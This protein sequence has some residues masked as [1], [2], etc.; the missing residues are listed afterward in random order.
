ML[1]ISFYPWFLFACKF[2]VFFWHAV[3]HS[4][5]STEFASPEFNHRSDHKLDLFSTDLK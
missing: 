5:Y 2:S 4:S 3:C 1:W